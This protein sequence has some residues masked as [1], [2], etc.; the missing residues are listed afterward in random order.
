[1]FLS[2]DRPRPNQR[3]WL[4]QLFLDGVAAPKT[5]RRPVDVGLSLS[6]NDT[7][8][9]NLIERKHLEHNY[10]DPIVS[11]LAGHLPSHHA[12]ACRLQG[13]RSLRRGGHHGDRRQS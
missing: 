10:P 8:I 12:L 3:L 2:D 13:A 9:A 11:L 5:Y 6:N 1:M 4:I 7:S